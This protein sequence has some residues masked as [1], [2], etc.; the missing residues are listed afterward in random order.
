MKQSFKPLMD[1][2]DAELMKALG[3]P[4]SSL[5]IMRLGH[6]VEYLAGQQSEHNMLALAIFKAFHEDNPLPVEPI[7]Q[8]ILDYHKD[9]EMAIVEMFGETLIS[10]IQNTVVSQFR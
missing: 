6:E 4:S 8:L 9:N 5:Q 3:D 7:L 2:S 10:K 1:I